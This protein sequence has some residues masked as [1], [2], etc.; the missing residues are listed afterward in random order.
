MNV[1]YILW[2]RQMK[3]YVR[4]RSRVIGSLAQPLLYLLGM[5]YGLGPVFQRAGMGSYVQFIAPGLIAMT[6]Q[7][8]SVFS[9]IELI[10]DRQFGFLK[11]TLVAPVPRLWIIL[12]RI[13]GGATVAFLQG[14]IFLLV[15]LIAGFRWHDLG[16]LPLA[17]LF[18]ALIGMVFTSV[19]SAIGS[20]MSDFQG[21]QFVVGFFIMPI[22]FL[23]GAMFPLTNLPPVLSLLTRLDPLSYGVDGLRHCLNGV[24]HFGLGT[25]VAVLAVVAALM[26]ALSSYLFS[27]IEL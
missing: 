9:G 12:G 7:F 24:V 23:S 11:E 21:F 27:K 18:M 8:T 26:L 19:G 5:G 22:F 6:I 3:R 1:I 25:D 20:M 14:L 15:C 2:L 13:L 17:F 16:S 4:S 10:M